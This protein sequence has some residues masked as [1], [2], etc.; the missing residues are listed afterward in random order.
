MF[1]QFISWLFCVDPG[2]GLAISDSSPITNCTFFRNKSYLVGGGVI[3]MGGSPVFTNCIFWGDEDY[4]GG[5]EIYVM[6][7]SPTVS[8]SNIKGGYSG[9]GNIDA[10]PLFVDPENGDFHLQL[11]SPCIDTGTAYTSVLPPKDFE[12]DPRIIGPAPDMGA[13]EFRKGKHKP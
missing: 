9:E 3:V 10:D 11:G 8:Y 7:G 13:D 2:G 12:G 5:S 4:Y 1:F 6:E